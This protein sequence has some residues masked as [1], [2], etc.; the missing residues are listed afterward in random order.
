VQ[1]DAEHHQGDPGGVLDGREL[2]QH[3]RA[4]D[5]G[6]H[7]QQGQHQGER[8][9]WQPGHGQLIAHV[10]DDGGAYADAGPGQQQDRVPERGQRAA[11]SPRRRHDRGD[12]HGRA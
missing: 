3:D 10:G 12:G 2:A 8:G 7:R 5:G 9:P 6:E 1:P 4:D 11:R